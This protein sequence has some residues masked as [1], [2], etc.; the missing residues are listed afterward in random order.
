M[1]VAERTQSRD[2][3]QNY[4]AHFALRERI[5]KLCQEKHNGDKEVLYKC[6]Q[7]CY[8]NDQFEMCTYTFTAPDIECLAAKDVFSC[9][10]RARH[11][12]IP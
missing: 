12:D 1:I 11:K 3:L 9:Q 7:N 5:C 10:Q 6:L 4:P 2:L 8:K